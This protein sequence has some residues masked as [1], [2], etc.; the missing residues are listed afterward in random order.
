MAAIYWLI[1]FVVLLGIE[2]AT[3]ALTTVWFAG[4]A[5]VAFVLALF[6]INIQVQ[7]AAFVIVSFILLFF[8]RP[9]AL[10]YVNQN[11]VKTNSESLIGK[12]AKV[13]VEINNTE[14]KGAAVLNG[15]EWTA[16]AL[17]DGR[18]YPAGTMV[19]VKEIRGVKLIVSKKQEES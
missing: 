16:R 8:T 10:K 11:T 1:A 9:F 6:G 14:G 18:I 7:L 3:M 4:G 2:A 5:L 12:Y 17:E 19:E 15:Q 13:T